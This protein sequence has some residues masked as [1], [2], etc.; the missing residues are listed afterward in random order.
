M[1]RTGQDRRSG[2]GGIALAIAASLVLHALVL[3]AWPREVPGAPLPAP[4]QPPPVELEV[5]VEVVSRPPPARAPAKAGPRPSRRAAPGGPQ[6]PA[7]RSPEPSTGW[8]ADAPLAAGVQAP[9]APPVLVPESPGAAGGAAAGPEL[10]YREG[11]APPRPQEPGES[12]RSVLQADKVQGG[13][14]HAYFYLLQDVLLAAWDADRVMAQRP[15]GEKSPRASTIRLIQ[16]VQGVLT[17]AEVVVPSWD[18]LLDREALEDLRA[19]AHSLPAPPPEVVR[20][21][22]RISSL[23]RFE[24]LP[25]RFRGGGQFDL[26]NLFDPRALPKPSD[27][28]I[29][30]LS[31]D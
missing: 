23:W 31:A 16:D 5:D 8:P 22:D 6:V 28:R 18:P 9:S 21:R 12:L 13:N 4:R 27:K 25:A 14:V 29:R 10:V 2:S 1:A 17:L 15:S 26:I 24:Y 3:L 19:A 7:A 30:L 11:L 20:G